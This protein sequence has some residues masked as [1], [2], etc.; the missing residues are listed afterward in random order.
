MKNKLQWYTIVKEMETS[1]SFIAFGKRLTQIGLTLVI[2]IFLCRWMI[3]HQSVRD[4][5]MEVKAALPSVMRCIS[6][7]NGRY[8]AAEDC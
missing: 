2:S 7:S 3:L 5:K 6:T 8:D 4:S 1:V